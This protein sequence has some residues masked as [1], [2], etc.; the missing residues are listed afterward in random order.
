MLQRQAK[1]KSVQTHFEI[2]GAT[3]N[4]IL[5]VPEYGLSTKCLRLQSRREAIL[6]IFFPILR[7][8][9]IPTKMKSFAYSGVIDS[10]R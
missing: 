2:P 7:K 9:Q 10:L 1:R 6:D 8:F 5:G 3:L 4:E